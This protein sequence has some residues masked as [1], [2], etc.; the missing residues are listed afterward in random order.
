MIVVRHGDVAARYYSL[1]ESAG[2]VS[3]NRWGVPVAGINSESLRRA[4]RDGGGHIGHRI[5]RDI[6]FSRRDL[7]Q[8]GYEVVEPD[9]DLV[10]TW[11]TVELVVG[12]DDLASQ[13][14]RDWQE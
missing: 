1:A 9:P 14:I 13:A 2:I 3:R 4:W 10:S 12:D 8:L 5:G 11:T 7:R 6:F